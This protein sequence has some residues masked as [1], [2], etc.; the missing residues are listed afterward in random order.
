V[1][2][3]GRP[4]VEGYFVSVSDNG[5]GVALEDQA[6]IF[7]RFTKGRDA[8]KRELPGSGLGL[9]IARHIVGHHGGKIWLRSPPGE[10]ATFCVFLPNRT[11]REDVS[12]G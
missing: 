5:R 6:F 1:T 3:V 12:F 11:T 2:I 7:E 8:A 9:A 4:G 10:G